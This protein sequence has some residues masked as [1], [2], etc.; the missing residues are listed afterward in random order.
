[1]QIEYF[2][3]LSTKRIVNIM[4]TRLDVSASAVFCF[5]STFVMNYITWNTI[6]CA[7]PRMVVDRTGLLNTS[8]PEVPDA[9]QRC[10]AKYKK[11]GF[12]VVPSTAEWLEA[13]RCSE[14]PYCSKSLRLVSDAATM[15]LVFG[16]PGSPCDVIDGGLSWR[17][18]ARYS[19][20]IDFYWPTSGMVRTGNGTQLG[21][22]QLFSFRSC[23]KLTKTYYQDI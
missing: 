3:D 18:A 22:T 21:E 15:R 23:G 8:S 12:N 1:M 19:C 20:I 9:T 10:I 16:P 4:Q 5:H 7:Y 2:I 11:R 17:L 6:V 14:H 13:H